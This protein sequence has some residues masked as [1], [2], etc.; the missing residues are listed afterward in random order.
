MPPLLIVNPLSGDG[1]LAGLRDEA[2]ARAIPVHMGTLETPIEFRIEPGALR[3]LV[4][5]GPLA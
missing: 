1:R 2:A 5:P 4:P 3:L